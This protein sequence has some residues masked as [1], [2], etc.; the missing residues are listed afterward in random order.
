M[1]FKLHDYMYEHCKN[2]CTHIVENTDIELRDISTYKIL[3]ELLGNIPMDIFNIIMHYL[4]IKYCEFR[5]HRT[6]DIIIPKFSISE[7][8]LHITI[9]IYKFEAYK[10]FGYVNIKSFYE[11]DHYFLHKH[12]NEFIQAYNVRITNSD[13]LVIYNESTN[14]YIV[15]CDRNIIW[16]NLK[17]IEEFVRKKENFMIVWLLTPINIIILVIAI[18]IIT[19]CL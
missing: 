19:G 11:K 12:N 6:T 1:D 9:G 7:K 18:I 4:A 15:S 2:R 14:E 16:N 13:P 10:R 3:E 8:M 17:S 5:S